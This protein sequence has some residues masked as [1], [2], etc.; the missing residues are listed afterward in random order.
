MPALSV[1]LLFA[2]PFVRDV[3]PDVP[4]VGI[5]IDITGYFF[6]MICVAL[7]TVISLVSVCR[8]FVRKLVRAHAKRLAAQEE[9]VSR[10]AEAEADARPAVGGR[11]VSFTLPPAA[12]AAKERQ[13][14]EEGDEEGQPQPWR[15]DSGAKYRLP[16]SREAAP[17]L[18]HCGDGAG[19]LL[20][21]GSDDCA[22]RV[23]R[24]SGAAGSA[25]KG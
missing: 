5:V 14:Q 8:R 21:A 17:E 15:G 10:K 16:G 12:D 13:L 20:A 11:A 2:L 25:S 3:Q 1:A 9:M 22:V 7:A 19:A 4:K 18:R 24:R 23:Y 6:N